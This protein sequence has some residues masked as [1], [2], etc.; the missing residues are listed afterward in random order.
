[1]TTMP[2]PPGP[3][4]SEALPVIVVTLGGRDHAI[5]AAAVEAILPRPRLAPVDGAA[6]WLAGLMDVRGALVPVVDGS[7]LLG[8]SATP[9]EVGSRVVLLQVPAPCGD[10][11]LGVARFGMLSD[12]VRE[13]AI[14]SMGGAAWRPG[15]REAIDRPLALVGRIGERPVP[16]LDPARIVGRERLLAPAPALV[17]LPAERRP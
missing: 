11:T 3:D 16:L 17:P 14:L 6:P 5:P 15:E 12:R 4:P 2:S 1:M 10:G 8:G 9:M 13:R 7:I